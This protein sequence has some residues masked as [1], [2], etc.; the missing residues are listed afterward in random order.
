MLSEVVHY[1]EL[2]LSYYFELIFSAF[3]VKFL[4]IVLNFLVNKL[5]KS[6]ALSTALFTRAMNIAAKI[7]IKAIENECL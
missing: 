3:R 1:S 4:F 2:Y 6:L 5:R 7:K